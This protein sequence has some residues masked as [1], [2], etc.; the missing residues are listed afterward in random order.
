MHG[1][2]RVKAIRT[3][4]SAQNL[5]PQQTNTEAK[6]NMSVGGGREL[7]ILTA[8]I[9]YVSTCVAAEKRKK[10]KTTSDPRTESK[11]GE[12]QEEEEEG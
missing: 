7:T 2:L 3:M 6:S 10:A 9:S 11:K 5:I 4:Q 8:T 1:T 12:K